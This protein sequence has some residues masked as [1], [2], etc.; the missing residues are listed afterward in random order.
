V[1]IFSGN[2]LVKTIKYR[3]HNISSNNQVEQLAVS[4]VLEAIGKTVIE[5][6]SPR[7]AAIFTDSKIFLNS[8]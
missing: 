8:I 7:T 1:A 6:N 5:E 4:E 2:E 3:L